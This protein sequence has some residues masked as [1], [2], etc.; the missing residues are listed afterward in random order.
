[1]LN[2]GLAARDERARLQSVGE[3]KGAVRVQMEFS[4]GFGDWLIANRVGLVCS[5]YQTGHLLFVG[6]RADGTP[7]PSAAGFSRAM[8][9]AASS[10]RIYAG[11]KNEIWRLEN[12]LAAD[13]IA[14]DTFDPFYAPRSDGGV[15]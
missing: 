4:G 7:V 9:L 12:I 1:M 11:T 8:G 14:N 5:T 10:Q 2:P 13:E 3:T 15:L 6:V